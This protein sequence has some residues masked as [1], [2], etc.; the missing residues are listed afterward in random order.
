MPPKIINSKER[1]IQLPEH[2]WAFH[3]VPENELQACLLFELNREFMRCEEQVLERAWLQLTQPEKEY[4]GCPLS[5]AKNTAIWSFATGDSVSI[6]RLEKL[7][8]DLEHSDASSEGRKPAIQQALLHINWRYSDTRITKDFKLLLKR[9][10]PEQFKLSR[11]KLLDSSGRR[12]GVKLKLVDLAIFRTYLADMTESES[13]K[14][15]KE[16]IVA[17]G[18][19][20][21][22]QDKEDSAYSNRHWSER[23]KDAKAML[24]VRKD[25]PKSRRR[26]TKAVAARKN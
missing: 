23:L 7:R 11:G 5:E 6:K 17:F 8:I 3:R 2:E 18:L 12:R 10:R 14:L 25:V 21:A 19:I 1:Q 22:H 20:S 24:G 16:M 15:L 4:W 26:V 9:L 13:F